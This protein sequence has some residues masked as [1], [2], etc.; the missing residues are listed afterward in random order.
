MAEAFALLMPVKMLSAAKS[1]LE[2]DVAASR[3]LM[4]AFTLDA[5]AAARRSPFVAQIHLVSDEQE[6]ADAAGV[7]LLR[8]E[9]G[10]DLNRALAAAATQV[11]RQHPRLGIAAMCADLPCLVETDLSL[12]LGSGHSARWCV[13][14]AAGTGTTLLVARPG[15]ELVPLF[16]PGSA[17]RHLDSG[18][19]P[20]AAD[21][22]TLRRDVD[23]P[24]DLAQ[25]AA[26]GVGPHTAATMASL[27]VA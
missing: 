11:R 20:V 4:A 2:L 14:D 26:L 21:V 25:A 6:L 9:G 22:P 5:V 15:I 7:S 1:R 10:G 8:D 3:S 12:A 17:Q 13:S 18:A 27:R 23:T 19:T 24:A 16:G